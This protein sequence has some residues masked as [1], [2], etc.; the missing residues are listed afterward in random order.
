[1]A[2]STIMMI[3]VA[4]VFFLAQKRFIEG[5]SATGITGWQANN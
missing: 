1:M 2:I 4:V 3:P 5:I